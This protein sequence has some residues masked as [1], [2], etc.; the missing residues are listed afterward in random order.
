M[1]RTKC[2]VCL[3][4]L[5]GSAFCYFSFRPSPAP[6]LYIRVNKHRLPRSSGRDRFPC[7]RYLSQT[8]TGYKTACSSWAGGTVWRCFSMAKAWFSRLL[9]PRATEPMRRMATCECA[10]SARAQV[11]SDGRRFHRMDRTTAGEE[12]KD[13]TRRAGASDHVRSTGG[14]YAVG[15]REPVRTRRKRPSPLHGGAVQSCMQRRTILSAM[16]AANGARTYRSLRRR[17]RTISSRAWT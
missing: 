14:I 13:L 6:N 12:R 7:L 10:W 11:P 1:S 5:A 15:T 2:A 8:L 3:L 9:A 17:R 16:T 4:A